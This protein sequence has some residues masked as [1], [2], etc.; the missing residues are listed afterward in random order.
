VRIGKP[1]EVSPYSGREQ[2][3]GL[4]E[5]ITLRVMREIGRLAGDEGFEPKI[6]GRRWKPDEDSQPVTNGE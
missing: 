5:E 3:D 1:I 4:M 2:E 6:A